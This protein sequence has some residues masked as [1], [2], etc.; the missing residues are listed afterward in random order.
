MGIQVSGAYPVQFALLALYANAADGGAAALARL[1]ST[2]PHSWLS[3]L[4]AYNA[5]CTMEA[6]PPHL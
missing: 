6:R 1:T 4:D 5:T 2:A 3:M